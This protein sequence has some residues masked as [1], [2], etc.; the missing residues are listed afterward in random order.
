MS[1]VSPP[2]I[3]CEFHSR[4]NESQSSLSSSRNNVWRSQTWPGLEQSNPNWSSSRLK[5]A[6]HV[7]QKFRPTSTHNRSMRVLWVELMDD[8]RKPKTSNYII[9]AYLPHKNDPRLGPRFIIMYAETRTFS[10][11]RSPQTR[12]G[13]P[14]IAMADKKSSRTVVARLLVLARRAVICWD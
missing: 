2:E 1:L 10:P 5:K 13:V 4:T 7:R 8:V 6:R 9:I 11:P 3:G 14:Y 12:N